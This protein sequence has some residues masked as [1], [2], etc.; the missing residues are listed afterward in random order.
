MKPSG[1]RPYCHDCNDG[2]G[3]IKN[4]CGSDS[5]DYE[6][7]CAIALDGTAKDCGDEE[8]TVYSHQCLE[9]SLA[10]SGSSGGRK[11]WYL[12]ESFY[13]EEEEVYG[14][15]PDGDDEPKREFSCGR[16][17]YYPFEADDPNL[18]KANPDLEGEPEAFATQGNRY[19]L[20]CGLAIQVCARDGDATCNDLALPSKGFA[21]LEE[22]EEEEEAA[23]V[24]PAASAAGE[25]G[26]ERL[27]LGVT[28]A[29]GAV[30]LLSHFI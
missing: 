4:V 20:D 29:V 28:A 21:S 24:S 13:C 19:C 2:N 12:R 5:D 14:S 8:M 15:G 9:P 11:H 23:K 3:N 17:W 10:D 22:E 30:L 27:K 6:E 26:G 1:K 16:E 7:V 18:I 25:S